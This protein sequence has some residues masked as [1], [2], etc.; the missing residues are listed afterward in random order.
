MTASVAEGKTVLV[1]GAYGGLGN[2]IA[3]QFLEAKAAVVMYS[4]AQ[5]LII[6]LLAL[7]SCKI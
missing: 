6:I 2:A 1:T 4:I 3:R 5:N 7:A